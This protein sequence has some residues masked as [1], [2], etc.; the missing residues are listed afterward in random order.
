MRLPVNTTAGYEGS[1]LVLDNTRELLSVI[2][3]VGE[4]LGTVSWA[5]VIDLVRSQ[6][7]GDDDRAAVQGMVPLALK[8]H[9]HAAGALS[10]EGLTAEFGG[11]GFFLETGTPL[12]VGTALTVEFSL[13]DQPHQRHTSKAKV[14]WVRH[15]P[16]RHL[17]L[18]GMEVQFVDLPESIHRQVRDLV[19]ALQRARR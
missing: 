3:P 12:P 19:S 5:S 10:G 14:V 18:P 15:K 6:R 11:G 16:E 2:S 4:V 17:F 9:Y 7:E 1:T 8:V 13:P